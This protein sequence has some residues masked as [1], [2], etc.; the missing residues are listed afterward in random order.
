MLGNH[1]FAD[2]RDPFSQR[3]RHGGDR[4][5]RERNAA[6]GRER[7]GRAA[8]LPRPARRRRPPDVRRAAGPSTRA[9]RLDGEPADPALPLPADRP[10]DPGR[11]PPGSRRAHPRRADHGAAPAQEARLAHLRARDVDGVYRSARRCCTSRPGSARRSSRFA[12][13]RGRRSPS[14]LY[15][16]SRWRAS[17]VIS[18]DVLA[19]YA[20][21]AAREVEGVSG[22]ARDAPGHHES[23]TLATDVVVL[24]RAR[25][26]TQRTGSERRGP[27]ARVAST[28]SAWPRRASARSTWSSSASGRRRRSNDVAARRAH[29]SNARD[30]SSVARPASG[31][32]AA[33]T[34]SPR[35]ASGSSGRRTSGGPGDD[36]PRR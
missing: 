2:S 23:P 35:S 21:D 8:R 30:R 33:A 3:D 10:A 14:W 6:G 27:G 13:S 26:G 12:S 24:P 11:L 22:L 4:G 1:D 16:R 7:R 32:R 36:L 29:R 31:G 25:V 17:S 20:G 34:G 28:W 18:T 19:R 15:D 9:R 5:A